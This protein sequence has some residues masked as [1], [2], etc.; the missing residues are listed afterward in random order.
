MNNSKTAKYIIDLAR[1]HHVFHE[2]K[3]DINQLAKK[4]IELSDDEYL[5][6]DI[7]ELLVEL[8]IGG[9]ITGSELSCLLIQYNKELAHMGTELVH[10][11]CV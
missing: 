1:K 5:L 10:E 11:Q 8:K 6:D 7:D 3:S 4:F 2:S 9:F